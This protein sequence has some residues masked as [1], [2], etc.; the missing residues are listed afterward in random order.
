[1]KKKLLFLSC[2]VL[3]A[4]SFTSCKSDLVHDE[5]LSYI[6]EELPSISELEDNVYIAYDR[7]SG[8]NYTDDETMYY[9]I[10][11]DV[12]PAS[13]KLVQAA[14][15]FS[16]TQES[17]KNVHEIYINAVSLQHE[18]FTIVLT[19][20]EMQDLDQVAAAN[21]KFGLAEQEM[22]KY[23]SELEKLAGEHNVGLTD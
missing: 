11:N 4:I 22:K 13:D 21:E 2:L 20:L 19:A 17:V 3:I 8:E 9:V 23:I 7:V 16:F 14:K 18:A 10:S 15:N 1:M 5:L 12:I 6:N